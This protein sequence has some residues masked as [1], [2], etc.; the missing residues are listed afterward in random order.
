VKLA[1]ETLAFLSAR[2]RE[3]IFS[4]TAQILYPALKDT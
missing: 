3:W 1:Q 4:S 2:D